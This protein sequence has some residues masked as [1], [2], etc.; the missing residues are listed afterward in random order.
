MLVYS[1]LLWAC[2]RAPRFICTLHQVAI[3]GHV[4][5]FFPN[6]SIPQ[7]VL[8]LT[9]ATPSVHEMLSRSHAEGKRETVSPLELINSPTLTAV[10]YSTAVHVSVVSICPR[11]EE[12]EDLTCTKSPECLGHPKSRVVSHVRVGSAISTCSSPSVATASQPAPGVGL[13]RIR[14]KQFAKTEKT[15]DDAVLLCVT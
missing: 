14:A 2:R 13:P 11:A 9:R 12:I 15:P 6:H 10:S 3:T 7:Q 1:K 5:I 4:R 8:S